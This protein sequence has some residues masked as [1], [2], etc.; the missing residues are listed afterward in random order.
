MDNSLKIVTYNIHKGFGVA[1]F[2]FVLHQIRR[3]LESTNADLL[4]LQ[5]IQGHHKKRQARIESWPNLPQFMF[6]AEN[7]WPH[8]AYGKNA[9]YR[10]GHHGNAILSK[11]PFLMWENISLA[12]H[13]RAS[14]SLL[15]AV[16]DMPSINNHLHIICIHF[17]L[18][19]TQSRKQLM[20]LK[21]RIIER[22]PEDAP[23]IIAGDFNDWHGQAEHFLEID[24]ALK[25]VFKVSHG[26]HAKT[27]PIW[28][29][30]L[31][32]DRI[33]YRGLELISCQRLHKMP[34]RK[35]SDHVPL[36]AEFSW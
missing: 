27:F 23:L 32:V 36:Y 30:K 25:E 29:P 31:A 3:A 26:Y 12:K 13:K 18:F 15:H 4:F 19:K 1:N 20:V 10:G 6:L 24:L 16:I 8:Y 14:R 22:I 11:F 34:W 21:N 28:S 9:L 35:L 5:E 7:F 17:A 33:Y 2:R